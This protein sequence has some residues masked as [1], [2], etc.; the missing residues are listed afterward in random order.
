MPSDTTKLLR[1]IDNFFFDGFIAN[2]RNKYFSLFSM[3]TSHDVFP[4]KD[5]N[6]IKEFVIAYLS[7][8]LIT[9][10]PAQRRCDNVA[11]TSWLMLWQRCS[12]VE[13]E[14]CGDVSARLCQDVA[15]TLLQR[16]L[17]IKHWSY[18]PFYYGQFWFLSRYRNVRELQ[19]C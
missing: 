14:S 12:T 1:I 15:T 6:C 17:N 4:K 9:A 13:N 8:R 10:Q 5:V 2:K 11:T 7:N 19:K 3:Y 16:H 18:K